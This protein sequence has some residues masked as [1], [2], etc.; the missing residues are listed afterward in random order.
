[1]SLKN[2]SFP[3]CYDNCE[4]VRMLGVG[5]CESC[6]PWKFDKDGNSIKQEKENKK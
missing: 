6:C 1:M 5:E 4:I 3:E 2:I